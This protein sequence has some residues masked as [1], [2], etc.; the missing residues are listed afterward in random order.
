MK[1]T[2]I[3][4]N[5]F[6][7]SE[8]K[9]L[10]GVISEIDALKLTV[11]IELAKTFS[12]LTEINASADKFQKAIKVILNAID[13]SKVVLDSEDQDDLLMEIEALM[14]IVDLESSGGYLN[15]WRYGFDPENPS[16][17]NATD[18]QRAQMLDILNIEIDKW[19]DKLEAN[20]QIK[21]ANVFRNLKQK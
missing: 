20:G 14:D 21:E 8:Q 13:N 18:E 5:S 16:I 2:L 3:K 1:D 9:K 4:L 15:E 19:G 7:L 11:L 17:V 6:I 12:G 10:Q